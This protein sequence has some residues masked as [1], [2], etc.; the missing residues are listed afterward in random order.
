MYVK[1]HSMLIWSI[2]MSIIF[3]VYLVHAA[4]YAQISLFAKQTVL[5][6]LSKGEALDL[7]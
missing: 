4:L 2:L 3:C 5:S 7:R 1:L 6:F